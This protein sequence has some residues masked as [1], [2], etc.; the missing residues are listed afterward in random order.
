MGNTPSQILLN[1]DRITKLRGKWN[2]FSG[3]PTLPM[4]HPSYLLRNPSEKKETW[5]DLKMLKIR[6]GED[7]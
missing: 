7:L 3:I 1:E 4:L 6:L 2:T 5:E